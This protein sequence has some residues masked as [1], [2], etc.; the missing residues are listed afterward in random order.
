MNEIYGS[1]YVQY[2]YCLE[3]T[4]KISR[5]IYDVFRHTIP[6]LEVVKPGD[7]VLDLGSGIGVSGHDLRWLRATT[8]SFDLSFY[9]QEKGLECFGPEKSN[10]RIVGDTLDLPFQNKSFNT[11]ISWELFEHLT[12]AQATRVLSEIER[13]IE[14][15]KIFIK[16][17]PVED[18]LNIDKDPTHITKWRENDWAFFFKENGWSTIK[19]PTRRLFGK[20]THG[21]FLLERT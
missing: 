11:A 19:N 6:V 3:R 17:T 5:R 14:N 12:P 8:V 16:L 9:A 4:H 13:V 15:N 18:S 21:N 10:L 1:N 20:T 2:N 7:K